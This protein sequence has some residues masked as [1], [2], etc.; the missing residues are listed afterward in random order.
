MF[1]LA[2]I[3]GRVDAIL[4]PTRK[5]P[6][7]LVI[8]GCPLQCAKKTMEQAGFSNFMNIELSS[9]GIKK[10]KTLPSEE[11]ITGVFEKVKIALHQSRTNQGQ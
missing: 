8:D 7:I 2:G 10:G 3:G 5:A 6:Q 1:C 11:T 4:N 9:F